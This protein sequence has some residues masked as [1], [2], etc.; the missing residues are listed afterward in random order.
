VAY[1]RVFGDSGTF[2]DVFMTP[3]SQ[4][5]GDKEQGSKQ[6][7]HIKSARHLAAS[8]ELFAKNKEGC[9]EGEEMTNRW[10]EA[11]GR[12]GRKLETA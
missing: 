8:V 1:N 9:E 5:G 6:P 7:A 4:G 11:I 3:V 10:I 2:G 12:P